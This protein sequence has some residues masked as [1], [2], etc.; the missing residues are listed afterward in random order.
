MHDLELIFVALYSAEKMCSKVNEHY[1]QIKN[2]SYILLMQL[3][4][5]FSVGISRKAFMRSF[6]QLLA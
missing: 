2:G 5:G 4:S 1:D 6:G 3:A